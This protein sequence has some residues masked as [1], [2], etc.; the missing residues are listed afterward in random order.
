MPKN[1]STQLSPFKARIHQSNLEKCQSE[2]LNKVARKMDLKQKI[3]KAIKDAEHGDNP[4]IK[5]SETSFKP[6]I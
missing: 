2:F 5:T 4:P 1:N 6:S 3:L